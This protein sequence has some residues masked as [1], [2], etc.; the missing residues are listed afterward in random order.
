MDGSFE[1]WLEE[2]GP[3]G[4]LIHMVDDATSTSLA[5][6]DREETTWGVARTLRAWV[7]KYGIP[8]ALYVDWKTVYHHAPTARQKLED[9]VPVSQF[10]RMCAKLGIHLIG[11]N[12]PRKAMGVKLSKRQSA[13]KVVPQ[14]TEEVQ[15]E[16]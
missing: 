14:C 1:H 11:A 12:P 10:G 16:A 9:I 3:K 8:G 6:F 2:R 15:C 13:G 5:T 7:E 4:C